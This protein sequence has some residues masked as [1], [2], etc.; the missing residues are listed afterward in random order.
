MRL[1]MD[2]SSVSS[3]QTNVSGAKNYNSTGRGGEEARLVPLQHGEELELA[4]LE[5]ERLAEE[6]ASRAAEEEDDAEDHARLSAPKGQYITSI[7]SFTN[8][9]ALKYY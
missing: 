4:C 2:G 7:S 5:A 9:I 8:S 6:E 3:R 1:T